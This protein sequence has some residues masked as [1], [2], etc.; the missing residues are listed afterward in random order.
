[1][2]TFISYARFF[3]TLHRNILNNKI[4]GTLQTTACHC[5]GFKLVFYGLSKLTFYSWFIIYVF[6]YLSTIVSSRSQSIPTRSSRRAWNDLSHL[7]SLDLPR[8][9]SIRPPTTRTYTFN[10]NSNKTTVYC[11]FYFSPLNRI[12]AY[13]RE[14]Q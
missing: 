6:W 13:F 11:N 12:F 4:C 3:I 1:M 14:T 5:N 2:Y 9:I 10:D 8:T 7:N